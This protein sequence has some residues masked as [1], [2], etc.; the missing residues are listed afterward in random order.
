MNLP[1]RKYYPTFKHAWVHDKDPGSG[2]SPNKDE[3]CISG[4]A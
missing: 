2:S 4:Y 3:A 1:G